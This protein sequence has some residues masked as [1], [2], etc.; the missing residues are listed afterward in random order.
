MKAKL[1]AAVRAVLFWLAIA[2][3]YIGLSGLHAELN[4]ELEEAS[5]RA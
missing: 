5:I 4:P 3:G 2:L 1:L